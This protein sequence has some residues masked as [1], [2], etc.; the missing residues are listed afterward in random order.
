[1]GDEAAFC[2]L[3]ERALKKGRLGVGAVSYEGLE[4]YALESVF[5]ENLSIMKGFF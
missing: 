5:D 2:S 3:V 1:V 4:A